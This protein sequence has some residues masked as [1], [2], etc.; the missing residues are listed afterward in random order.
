MSN[1]LR[2]ARTCLVLAA[3]VAA[4]LKAADHVPAWLAGTPHGARVYR[5]VADA[6]RAIGASI[7]VP[8]SLPGG[9]AWPPAR[10]DAWPGPPPS[11][12]I[13]V[14]GREDGGERLVLVQSIGTPAAPPEALLPP[15]QALM[16]VEVTVGRHTATLTRALAQ[17][18]Q[19]L[20]DLSWDEGACRLTLR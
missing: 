14:L 15:V 19:L 7:R 18:G 4:V 13:R 6:E 5:T 17:S 2:A 11:V 8:S 1:L 10:V 20:H 12:A 3:G 16:A 9:L